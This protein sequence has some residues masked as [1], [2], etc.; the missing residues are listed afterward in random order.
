[1]EKF[2]AET[3]GRLVLCPSGVC[4]AQTRSNLYNRV[5]RK[6]I[7]EIKYLIKLNG[8]VSHVCKVN[9]FQGE[10]NRLVV[11]PSGNLYLLWYWT[12]TY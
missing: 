10:I 8:Q 3:I 4:S 5:S 6:S 9:P 2:H 7:L 11:A 12:L 1:M